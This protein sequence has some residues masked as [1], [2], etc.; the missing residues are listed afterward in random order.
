MSKRKKMRDGE[1]GVRG[2]WIVHIVLVLGCVLMILPFLWM[3]LTAFKTTP[4]TLKFP[5]ILVPK[6][7]FGEAFGEGGAGFWHIFSNFQRVFK[8]M[9]KMGWAYYNTF[10]MMF[11]RIACA[12]VFSSTAAYAFAK[13][14]FPLKNALF[15]I[16]VIQLMLPSQI[17]LTYQYKMV[18][19]LKW[20]DTLMGLLFPGLVSAFGVFFMRQ[21]Y[22][23]LPNDL[24][25]AARLDGCNHWQIFTRIMVPLTKTAL[26]ALSI[27]TAVFA[28]SDLLWPLVV[29][30]SRESAYTLS[31]LLVFLRARE[32]RGVTTQH[33]MAASL[34]AMLPMVALYTAFQKQF[35]EGIALTGTKA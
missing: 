10:M 17:F 35:I 7:L 14:H 33:F 4:E 19:N 1:V 24:S 9:P 25:E 8:E 29:N 23:S 18:L 5:P 6:A 31:T 32:P 13:M 15:S 20:Q 28:W 12:A 22:M 11:L 26:M 3:V 27:F 34:M 16:V 21:F 2:N 30:S